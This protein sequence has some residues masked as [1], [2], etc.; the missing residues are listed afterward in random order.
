MTATMPISPI[1]PRRRTSF[2][3]SALLRLTQDV[4]KSSSPTAWRRLA[5]DKQKREV[6]TDSND[7]F[8]SARRISETMMKFPIARRISQHLLEQAKD[9]LQPKQ[10]PVVTLVPNNRAETAFL[11][12]RPRPMPRTPTADA[13]SGD[14]NA[15]PYCDRS[16][17]YPS[18][19]Q[20]HLTTHTGV[21]Q[22]GCDA[23]GKTF[24]RAYTLKVHRRQHNGQRPYSCPSCP[25]QYVEIGKLNMHVKRVHENMKPW[26]CNLCPKRFP[27]QSQWTVHQRV[28]TGERPFQCGQ[29]PKAFSVNSSLQ[30]HQLTHVTV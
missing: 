16:F 29:C 8:Q 21:K 25:K 22:F 9:A 26:Q 2:T 24:T 20:Q 27:C 4:A 11:P 28:H 1:P 13:T 18:M 19:L 23:C 7:T 10:A 17:K 6:S 30:R 5:S 12:V 3:V 15:C 14:T